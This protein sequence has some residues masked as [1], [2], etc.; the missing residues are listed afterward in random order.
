MSELSGWPTVAPQGPKQSE[1]EAASLSDWG[2][3]L[4]AVLARVCSPHRLSD[5]LQESLSDQKR[6]RELRDQFGPGGPAHAFVHW[7]ADA[8]LLTPDERELDEMRTLVERSF[9]QY[10]LTWSIGQG[11]IVSPEGTLLQLPPAVWSYLAKE[12]APPQDEL[13]HSL[14]H[15]IARVRSFFEPLES[16]LFGMNSELLQHHVKETIPREVPG[17][18]V[19]PSI[20]PLFGKHQRRQGFHNS[21]SLPAHLRVI[22]R[23]LERS[24]ADNDVVGGLL[25]TL[26]A[27]DYTV[28]FATG[29]AQGCWAAVS[30]TDIPGPFAPT[31]A[32]LLAD[33]AKVTRRL[34]SYWDHPHAQPALHLLFRGKDLNPF[35]EW[36]GLETSP[37]LLDWMIEAETAIREDNPARCAALSEEIGETFAIWMAEFILLC[38]AW[39]IVSFTR[40]DGYLATSVARGSLCVNCKPL[41]DPTRYSVWLDRSELTAVATTQGRDDSSGKLPR[42][43]P[44]IMLC[45]NDPPLLSEHISELLRAHEQQQLLPLGR[46]LLEGLEYLVRLQASLAGGYLRHR[47]AETALLDPVLTPGSSL[48][49]T[50]LFLSYAQ[51][52]LRDLDSPE[53]GLLKT[54]FFEQDRPRRFTRWLGVDGVPG[55]LQGLIGWSLSLARP[56]AANRSDEIREQIPRLSQL[57]AEF[58][59]ASRQLWTSARLQVESGF[60]D[61]QVT[62]CQFPS[63]LRVRGVPDIVVGHRIEQGATGVVVGGVLD[64]NPFSDWEPTVLARRPSRSPTKRAVNLP[65]HRFLTTLGLRLQLGRRILPRSWPEGASTGPTLVR[66]GAP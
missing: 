63:G 31:T 61:S 45:S 34:R 58:L 16:P 66:R 5:L 20:V 22:L 47:F 62:V 12:K 37:R 57:F 42:L 59:E 52:V 60:E 10:F 38:S 46:G 27:T 14:D 21:S 55:P 24:Q 29:L 25:A 50:L 65:G 15:A 17:V 19:S 32:Q 54:V 44:R 53:A 13:G 26:E 23:R 6:F 39:D 7:W 1:P 48:G 33:L 28:R 2:R 49:H 18:N 3:V 35:L 56:D 9:E 41:V 36:A 40:H 43:D 51:R 4:E 11:G 30:E 8:G 64:S